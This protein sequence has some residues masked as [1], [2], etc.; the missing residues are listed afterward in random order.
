MKADSGAG[1]GLPEDR[2]REKHKDANCER[3]L[4]HDL[5]RGKSPERHVNALVEDGSAMIRSFASQSSRGH[6]AGVSSATGVSGPPFPLAEAAAVASLLLQTVL[7]PGARTTEGT[8]IEAVALPWFDIIAI[9]QI[10]PRI[11]FQL[12]WEKWEEIIAGAYTKAGF[13]E[14]TLTPRSGTDAMLLP[15]KKEFALSG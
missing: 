3:D 2:E 4:I 11:A 7:V 15:S 1:A 6:A 9:L 8:L 12:S 14:V 5:E 13:E 10:D